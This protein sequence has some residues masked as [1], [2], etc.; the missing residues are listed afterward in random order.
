MSQEVYLVDKNGQSY[1]LKIFASEDGYGL[2]GAAELEVLTSFFHPSIIRASEI[3]D[4]DQYGIGILLP[5]GK[6]TLKTALPILEESEIIRGMGDLA[7]A[8]AFLHKHNITSP[9]LKLE[10]IIIRGE[11]GSRRF[12]LASLENLKP[13]TED[14]SDV[15][16]LGLLYFNLLTRDNYQPEKKN[17]LSYLQE[18]TGKKFPLSSDLLFRMLDPDKENRITSS[19]VIKSGFFITNTN[20]FEPESKIYIDDIDDNWVS[21]Y[22]IS[23]VNGSLE[24]ENKYVQEF[25][26]LEKAMIIN[27]K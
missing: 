15:Y 1:G 6:M 19:D 26:D 21:K 23:K 20:Y 5:L 9:S 8:L 10:D 7:S 13:M 16:K 27:R 12:I 4:L 11:I 18:K 22:W 2:I 17:R 25:L 14:N 24:T 3:L